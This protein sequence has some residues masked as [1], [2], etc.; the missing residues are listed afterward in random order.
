MKVIFLFSMLCFGSYSFASGS[1]DQ[2]ELNCM[3]T[4]AEDNYSTFRNYEFQYHQSW[5][6]EK[7]DLEIIQFKAKKYK[8]LPSPNFYY[9]IYG[10][11][12]NK[13]T[14]FYATEVFRDIDIEKCLQ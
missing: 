7:D 13:A 12:Y 1:F 6:I 11:E 9:L 3:L 5:F 2:S 10:S 8:G 14:L 4:E